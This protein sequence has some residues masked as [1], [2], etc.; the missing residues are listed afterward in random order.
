VAVL[1]VI[2][3]TMRR[4]EGFAIAKETASVTFR[5]ERTQDEFV[6]IVMKA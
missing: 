3:D 4:R 6:V 2:G 5:S 1:R